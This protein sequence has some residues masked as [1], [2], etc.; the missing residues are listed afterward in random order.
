MLSPRGK[1]GIL[2]G[3]TVACG[4]L[5]ATLV[6]WHLGSPVGESGGGIDEAR[7]V[8]TVAVPQQRGSSE[9]KVDLKKLSMDD[10]EGLFGKSLQRA[11][12]DR[13][14]PVV[15]EPVM[16]AA[17][18]EPP[19][20]PPLDI[21]FVGGLIQSDSGAGRAWVRWQ[22]QVHG[23]RVGTALQT[24]PQKPVLVRVEDDRAVFRIGN[25]TEMVRRHP[26][27]IFERV[28]SGDNGASSL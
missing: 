18:R 20:P 23:V 3:H 12:V 1:D 5:T 14:Q 26:I 8:P 9:A 2:Y 16:A 13:P 21:E 17:R 27:V 19:A 11:V 25:R 6:I 10:F 24:H 15:A 7:G 22:G 28:E 4:V